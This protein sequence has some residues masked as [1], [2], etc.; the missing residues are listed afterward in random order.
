MPDR[1]DKFSARAKRVMELAQQEAQRYKNPAIDNQH[2]LLGLV[3]EGEGVAA[4]VLSALAGDLGRVR[5]AVEVHITPGSELL[6]GEISITPR[7]KK[8]IELA[9]D[10]AR[11]L[12]HGYIGTEHL[13]LGLLREGENGAMQAL[14]SLGI[15]IERVRTEATRILAQGSQAH[16]ASS[17]SSGH[18][19]GQPDPMLIFHLSHE[20]RLLYILLHRL[21]GAKDAAVVADKAD[22]LAVLKSQEALMQQL[23]EERVAAVRSEQ[24]QGEPS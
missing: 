10:E 2:L 17:I 11:R 12:N 22:A 1:F 8:T 4:K 14:T 20:L 6:H 15:S 18:A 13:L 5:A 16:A 9:V 24:Q 19:G 3:D 23:F 21:R 7:A